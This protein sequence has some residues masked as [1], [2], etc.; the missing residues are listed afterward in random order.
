[1]PHRR[2]ILY[3]DDDPL[4]TEVFRELFSDRYDVRTAATPSEA[5]RILRD[6]VPDIV[7]SD[8]RMP[9]MDGTE[10]LREAARVCPD[11]FRV[12][13]TG[14]VTVGSVLPE[15]AAGLV[16]LFLPKPWTAHEMDEALERAVAGLDVRR[17]ARRRT[18][19]HQ[20]R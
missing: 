13:L 1:M 17:K 16:Q 18:R 20:K 14:A 12:L 15:V 3:L 10:F 5:R 2:V 7:I 4:Q 6:C 9:E 8:H 19:P 11:S